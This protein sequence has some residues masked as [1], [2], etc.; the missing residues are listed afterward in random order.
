VRYSVIALLL[1]TAIIAGLLGFW[2]AGPRDGF[3]DVVPF[4][5]LVLLLTIVLVAGAVVVYGAFRR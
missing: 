4:E 2:L 1:L 5:F 3:F